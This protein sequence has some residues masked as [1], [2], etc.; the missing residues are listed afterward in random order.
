MLGYIWFWSTIVGL[1][2]YIYIKYARKAGSYKLMDVLTQD[3]DTA[4]DAFCISILIIASVVG[5][6]VGFGSLIT[7]ACH[8]IYSFVSFLNQW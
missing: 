6:L 7:L 1:I 2:L 8:C 3:V 5:L 4:F